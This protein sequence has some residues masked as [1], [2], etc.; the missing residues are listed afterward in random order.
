MK[1]LVEIERRLRTL[2]TLAEAIGAMKSLSAHH[3]RETRRALDPARIYREGV[4]HIV[5]RTG[6]FLPAGSGAAGLLIV[7]GELGVC[8]SYNAR[9]A[10]AGESHRAALG[11]GPT[12]AVGRRMATILGRR[13]LVPEATWSTPTS[14]RG[15]P[16]LLLALAEQMLVTYVEQD[17]SAFDIVSA[18]FE[19]VGEH[20]PIVTRLLPVVAEAVAGDEVVLR[21]ATPE[22]LRA[23]AVREML[24]VTIHELLLDALA[25]EHGARLVATQAAH[26]WLDER[27][28]A[29]Q[30]AATSGRREAQTQEM[31]EVAAGAR[32]RSRSAVTR[33]RRAGLSGV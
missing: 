17:L 30:R 32:A 20:R 3:F 16:E 29:L 2:D 7:G 15:I 18:R 33:P 13:G 1:R 25:A 31:L 14:V 27:R 21:Y 23:A 26:E 11:P 22:H 9:L 24:Y 6:A 28:S 10:A 8:G 19:G 12:L 5:A 4:E